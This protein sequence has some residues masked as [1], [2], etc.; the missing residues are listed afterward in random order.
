M[1][2]V[3][4]L[5][6]DRAEKINRMREILDKCDDEKRQMNTQESQEYRKLDKEVDGL[7]ERIEAEDRT[8]GLEPAGQQDCESLQR[9]WHGNRW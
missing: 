5:R 3:M 8:S 6:Q 4:E 9:D 2:R 7:T 1:T